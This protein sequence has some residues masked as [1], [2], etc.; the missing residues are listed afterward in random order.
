MPCPTNSRTT[1]KPLASTCC[2]TAAPMS[3]TRAPART[4]LMA[5]SSAALGHR[6]Q[7]LGFRRDLPDRHRHR[8]IAEKPVQLG[9]HVNRQDVA[10]DQRPI[11]RD[12]VNHLLVH[13]RAD[14]RR[15]PVIPL[16]R[17]QG[18]RLD[19]AAAR[20][21]GP[22]R[23]SSSRA[24]PPSSTPPAPAPPAHSP[25]PA[26]RASAADRQVIMPALPAARRHRAR[27]GTTTPADAARPV[28]VVTSICRTCSAD[29]APSIAR[30]VGRP[31]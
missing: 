7:P 12:P 20:R 23:S 13:R 21:A 27:R 6:Q 30:N 18:P 11:V 1:E 3:C 4:T 8:R 25:A 14:G 2:C 10:L 31:L 9:A 16:E 17:R 24:P 19:A 26:A 22:G 28:M 5:R 15:I 29:C